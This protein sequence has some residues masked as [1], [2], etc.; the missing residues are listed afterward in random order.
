MYFVG[1]SFYSVKLLFIEDPDTLESFFL[2]FKQYL[3]KFSSVFLKGDTGCSTVHMKTFS[4][5]RNVKT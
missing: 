1:S 4:P 2:F 5:D 3:N